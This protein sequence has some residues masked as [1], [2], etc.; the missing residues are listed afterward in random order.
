MGGMVLVRQSPRLDD[1]C[2]VDRGEAV[3]SVMI[4]PVNGSTLT[5]SRRVTTTKCP[6][7]GA[8]VCVPPPGVCE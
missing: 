2:L 5:D 8:D 7:D 3:L 4:W 1:C 6:A